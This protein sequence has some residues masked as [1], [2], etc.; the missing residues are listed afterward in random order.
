MAN[1]VNWNQV[2]SRGKSTVKTV[3]TFIVSAGLVIIAWVY[4]VY[5]HVVEPIIKLFSK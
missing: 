5:P 3:A 1:M 4:A 2:R